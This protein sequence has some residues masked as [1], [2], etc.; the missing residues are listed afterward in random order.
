MGLALKGLIS[1]KIWDQLYKT[2]RYLGIYQT[3]KMKFFITDIELKFSYQEKRAKN[4]K[5]ILKQS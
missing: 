4:D 5:N 1:L 3:S 2:E